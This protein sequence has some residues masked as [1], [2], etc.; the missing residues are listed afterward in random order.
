MILYF[1]TTY[2]LFFT[3]RLTNDS[4]LQILTASGTWSYICSDGFDTNSAKSVCAEIGFSRYFGYNLF[5]ENELTWQANL[6]Y[7]NQHRITG[8][9]LFSCIFRVV[10]VWNKWAGLWMPCYLFELRKMFPEHKTFRKKG[11]LAL[12]HCCDY[13]SFISFFSF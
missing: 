4:I 11:I 8:T 2:S 9:F 13:S 12:V 5:F 1:N 6:S 10:K 3:V 7:M